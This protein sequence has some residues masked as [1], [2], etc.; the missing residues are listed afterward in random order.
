MNRQLQSCWRR[1]NLFGKGPE[2]EHLKLLYLLQQLLSFATIAPHSHRQY[3][4]MKCRVPNPSKAIWKQE[5]LAQGHG[6]PGKLLTQGG[7]WSDE[8]FRMNYG[9]SWKIESAHFR[10][11]VKQ[12]LVLSRLSV[13]SCYKQMTVCGFQSNFI[14]TRQAEFQMWPTGHSVLN[15]SAPASQV[16]NVNKSVIIQSHLQCACVLSCV[17]LFVTPWTVA[18]Q[19]PLS[20]GTSRQEYWSGLPFPTPG[21][22]PDPGIKPTSLVSPALAGR[23]FTTSDT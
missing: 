16:R 2:N 8:H 14:Y 20:M 6:S 21:H 3:T 18:C 19:A 11:Y 23:F 10:C 17:Q 7:I 1:T 9:A 5:D 13:I 15:T 22:F 12:I 4:T